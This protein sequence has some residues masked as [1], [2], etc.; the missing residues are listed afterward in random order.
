MQPLNLMLLFKCLALTRNS[1]MFP[2]TVQATA[3][4]PASQ[5]PTDQN[6]FFV[7]IIGN[8]FYDCFKYNTLDTAHPLQGKL[9]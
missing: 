9:N 6:L 2:A 1:H 3:V 4:P 5:I 8:G 7:L